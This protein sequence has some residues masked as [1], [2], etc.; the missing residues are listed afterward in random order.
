VARSL[1]RAGVW[2]RGRQVT[3]EFAASIEKLGYGAFWVGGSPPADL[4]LPEQLL[5]ATSE[6]VVAT[7]VVNIWASPAHD[8]ARSYHRVV[9]RHPGR[10]LLG[11]GVGHPE[12]TRER[13]G[14]PYAALVDYLDALSAGGVPQEDLVLAAL[15]PRVLRL[16]AE[17]TAGAHP[18]LTTPEHTRAAR[19]ILG[20][21]PLL[22]P[23]Q[24]VVLEA[25]PRR[26]REI[27]RPPVA[28]PYLGLVNY[29]N[30]LYRLGFTDEDMADGGSDALVDA[31]VAHGDDAS[32]A[33]RVRQHLEVGAD[34]VCL[35][36]LPATAPDP[37]DGFRR[38]AEV[39]LR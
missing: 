27:G 23:E 16:A 28:K 34:H 22:A 31:L 20:A 30:N 5:D 6:I 1:G 24:K 25:D 13:Y 11:I 14:R 35:Q 12:A 33:A 39:L 10:F 7:G 29:R 8:V 18:Y 26:A 15:G 3:P 38:L 9:A 19:E 21:G 37:L 32:V 4:E 17:R 36:L 2:A